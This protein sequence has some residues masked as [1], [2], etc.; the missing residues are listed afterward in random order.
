MEMKKFNYMLAIDI[1][2]NF[3]KIY[4]GVLRGAF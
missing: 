2:R 3:S 1:L 4:L